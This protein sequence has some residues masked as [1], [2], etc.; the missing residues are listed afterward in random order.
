MRPEEQWIYRNRWPSLGS[1]QEFILLQIDRH[2][3]PLTRGDLKRLYGLTY[4]AVDSA[5]LNLVHRRI[6]APQTIGKRVTYR[7]LPP[8]EIVR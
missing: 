8:D 5:L 3:T 1:Q 2:E 7:L 6:I 4:S